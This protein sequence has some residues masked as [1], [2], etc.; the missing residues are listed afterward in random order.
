MLNRMLNVLVL[1]EVPEL[2]GIFERPLFQEELPTQPI[3]V[4]N[5]EAFSEALSRD[6]LLHTV[7]ETITSSRTD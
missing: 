3:D 6:A 5:H 2:E 4:G 7:S 1:G